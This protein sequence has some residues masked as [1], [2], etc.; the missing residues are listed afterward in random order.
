[1]Q[2]VPT[3]ANVQPKLAAR[4][5]LPP[6]I[7][8]TISAPTAIV[9][10][11]LRLLVD[12][13]SRI[14]QATSIAQ[15]RRILVDRGHLSDAGLRLFLFEPGRARAWVLTAATG[16]EKI[17]S[18]APLV[19]ALEGEIK[20]QLAAAKPE[21]KSP[22]ASL[23]PFQAAGLVENLS[24]V[25]IFP[26][27]R[28]GRIHAHLLCAR[29]EVWLTPTIRLMERLA[30]S[31]A[32]AWSFH[33]R[34]PN[35]PFMAS[36]RLVYGAVVVSAL[37]LAALVPVPMTALAPARVV[38]QN[39]IVIAAPIDGVISDILVQPNQRVTRGQPLLTYVDH[40]LVARAETANRE[41]SVVEAKLR[42]TGMLALSSPEA[43]R[44]LAVAEAE[45]AVRQAERDHAQEQ[46]RRSR[47][48]APHDG[49]ALF[50]D[51]KD[52]VGR[53]VAAGER[54]L[55]IG[56]PAHVEIQIEVPVEDAIAMKPGQTVSVFLDTAP[57]SPIAAE[58][59]RINNEPRMLEGRGLAFVLNATIRDAQVPVLG[60]R[61]TGHLRGDHVPLGFFLLRRPISAFRQWIGL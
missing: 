33:K 40:Q 50:A 5:G 13:E 53:P 49:I 43:K 3:P 19:A 1:M 61:G 27:H 51:R 15:L 42:R 41:A 25:M 28:E 24:H 54:I 36:R 29:S 9:P 6:R 2:V 56:D 7:S 10:A 30:E 12:V 39:P 48:T 58:V 31:A 52:W 22:M 8:T 44:E 38:T 46:V 18:D 17:D 16:I 26:L 47:V 11:G 4:P 32:F 55:E 20:R 37:V 34:A 35:V 59:H 21:G 45:L 23:G 60:A 14:R 57:L